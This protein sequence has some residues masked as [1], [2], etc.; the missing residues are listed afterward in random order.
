MTYGDREESEEEK[1]KK[2]MMIMIMIMMLIVMRIC[3]LFTYS[4]I[5]YLCVSAGL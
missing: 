2:M 1:K 5:C 4:L 3:Q